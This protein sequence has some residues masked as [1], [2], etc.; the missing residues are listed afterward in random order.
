MVTN[1]EERGCPLL[2]LP[3]V[4]LP[5]DHARRVRGAG[6]AAAAAADMCR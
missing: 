2:G 4:P 6:W 5:S 1:L 3:A